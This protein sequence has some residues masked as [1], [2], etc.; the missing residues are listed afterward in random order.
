MVII[1]GGC[2]CGGAVGASEPGRNI[3]GAPPLRGMPRY[4]FDTYNGDN[5]IPDEAGIELEDIEAAKLAAQAALPEMARDK[6]PDGDQR[7]FIV[8]VRD[9]AGQVVLRVALSLVVE[10][11]TKAQE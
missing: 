9:E 3:G 11:G 7:V 5:F 8:S 2:G 10:Y 4:F 6:L 1:A